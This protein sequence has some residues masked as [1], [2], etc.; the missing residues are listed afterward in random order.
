MN[1]K[2]ATMKHVILLLILLTQGVHA[3]PLRD[4]MGEAGKILTSLLNRASSPERFSRKGESM[5]V[6]AELQRLDKLFRENEVH[7]KNKRPTP[8]LAAL[9]GLVREALETHQRGQLELARQMVRGLPALCLSCHSQDQFH[10]WVYRTKE[11]EGVS[12]LE[13][14]EFALAT[15]R[16][17]EARLL[18]ISYFADKAL[19]SDEEAITAIRLEMQIGLWQDRPLAQIES[20]VR[21][22]SARYSSRQLVVRQLDGWGKGLALAQKLLKT[23]VKSVLQW[24][25]IMKAAFG[26]S[27]PRLGLLAPPDDEALFM[28]FRHELHRLL[29]AGSA[30]EDRPWLYYWL[31]WT[32]RGIGHDFLYSL[33]DGYLRICMDQWPKSPAAKKCYDEFKSFTEFAYTGSAGTSIPSEVQQELEAY[34]KKVGR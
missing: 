23:P 26:D 31:S 25:G 21:K 10:A 13:K 14:A 27:E 3:A 24:P 4:N 11:L 17:E 34:R 15:R 29:R 18:L 16:P 5:L 8:E 2:G 12:T 1:P 22:H 7:F 33:G 30:E 32:E 6:Q 20:D 19:R 28:S 9:Q